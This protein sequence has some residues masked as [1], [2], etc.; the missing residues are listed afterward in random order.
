LLC[1]IDNSFSTWLLPIWGVARTVRRLRTLKQS[2]LI[3]RQGFGDL[4]LVGS[5]M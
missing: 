4:S 3:S 5:P 1:N 2:P